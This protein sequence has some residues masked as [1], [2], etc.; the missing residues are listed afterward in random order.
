M[1]KKI[2]RLKVDNCK[3]EMLK[4]AKEFQDDSVRY[5]IDFKTNEMEE[6]LKLLQHLYHHV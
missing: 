2:M 3:K 4:K 5:Q 1:D 6:L